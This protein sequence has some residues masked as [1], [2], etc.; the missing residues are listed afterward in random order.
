MSKFYVGDYIRWV[1]SV[2]TYSASSHGVVTP[3]EKEYDYGIVLYIAEAGELSNGDIIIA[4]SVVN[5]TWM[6]TD[7]NDEQ[8]EI[9]LMSPSPERP[10][11]GRG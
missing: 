5:Q 11:K 7:A 3:V 2:L 4:R 10:T 8:Y 6:M 9:A 1:K